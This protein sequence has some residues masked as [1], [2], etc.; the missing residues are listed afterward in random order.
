MGKIDICCGEPLVGTMIFPGAE[1]FCTV[2]H[3]SYGM[4][5][6]PGRAD[7]TPEM[8]ARHEELRM[9]FKAIAKDCI[10]PRSQK[11]DC[12]QCTGDD[13]HLIHAT[14]AEIEASDAAYKAL[15]RMA[16]N[17]QS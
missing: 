3:S 14:E 2:C 4:F 12:P 1:Y 8:L 11:Q 16:P 9:Q 10:P 6:A 7:A 17:G 15:M 5:G 13:Y